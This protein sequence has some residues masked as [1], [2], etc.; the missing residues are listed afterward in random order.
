MNNYS[1]P[2]VTID[3]DEYNQLL[4]MK[5]I[6]EEVFSLSEMEIIYRF[7]FNYENVNFGLNKTDRP[8][9]TLKEYFNECISHIKS[10]R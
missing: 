10:K 5:E 7:G 3:L 8:R 4:K 1:K 6:N 2:Q 9:P